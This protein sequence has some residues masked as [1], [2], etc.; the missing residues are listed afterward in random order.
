MVE[1]IARYEA[2]SSAKSLTLN[3]VCVRA[4]VCVFVCGRIAD[5]ISFV[6]NYPVKMK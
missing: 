6:L 5:F 1:L 4:C 2:V 3:S